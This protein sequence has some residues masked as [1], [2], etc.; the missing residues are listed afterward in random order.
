[1]SVVWVCPNAS[2]ELYEPAA[3]DGKTEGVQPV[4]SH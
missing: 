2:R 3:Q 1:L 4:Q